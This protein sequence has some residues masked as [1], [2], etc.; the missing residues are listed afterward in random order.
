MDGEWVGKRRSEPSYAQFAG[1][2][3]KELT[4]TAASLPLM[5][6]HSYVQRSGLV[7]SSENSES[8]EGDRTAIELTTG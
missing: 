7:A 3:R 4:T 8:T 5:I 6:T 2:S 1:V